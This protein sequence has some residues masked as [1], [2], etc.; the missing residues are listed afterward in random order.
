MRVTFAT[1]GFV[2]VHFC[3]FCFV[4]VSFRLAKRV[5]GTL[6]LHQKLR[7]CICELKELNESRDLLLQERA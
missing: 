3:Y 5:F 4:K 2:E 1:L 6:R 7:G